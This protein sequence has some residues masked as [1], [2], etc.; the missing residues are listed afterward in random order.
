[1][2]TIEN[3]IEKADESVKAGVR[4]LV[5][6]SASAVLPISGAL[7]GTLLAGPIGCIVSGSVAIGLGTAAGGG[8]FGYTFAKLL[9]NKKKEVAEN[10]MAT[11]DSLDQK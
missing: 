4:S 10:D 3:N 5:K 11:L 1:M 9:K 8:T 7:L 2:D 6:A